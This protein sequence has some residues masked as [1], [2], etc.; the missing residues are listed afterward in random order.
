MLEQRLES[1]FVEYVVDKLDL[2]KS[3]LISK[4]AQNKHKIHRRVKQANRRP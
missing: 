1:A 2:H 3:C 4:P